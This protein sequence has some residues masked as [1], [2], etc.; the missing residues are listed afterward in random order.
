ME[1]DNY[2]RGRQ[3]RQVSTRFFTPSIQQSHNQIFV[4]R[5]QKKNGKDIN[6]FATG[7]LLNFSILP[8]TIVACE[9]AKTNREKKTYGSSVTWVF[10]ETQVWYDGVANSR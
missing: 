3:R 9:L 1:A 5:E 7:I 4:W 2:I 6:P 8:F 10:H